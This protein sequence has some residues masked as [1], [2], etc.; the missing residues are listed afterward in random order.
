MLFGGKRILRFGWVPFVFIF[1]VFSSLTALFTLFPAQLQKRLCL[2]QSH[3]PL[4]GKSSLGQFIFKQN[5]PS[6]FSF[7]NCLAY[8]F[9]SSFFL[10]LGFY[11]I[12]L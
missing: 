10:N 6:K 8:G 5:I 3:L 7:N 9:V 1:V 4:F 11:F 12:A 2:P